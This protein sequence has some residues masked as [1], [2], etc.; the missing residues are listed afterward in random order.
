M[1]GTI[2]LCRED[3]MRLR[4]A[5]QVDRRIAERCAYSRGHRV[6]GEGAVERIERVPDGGHVPL[7]EPPSST[8]VWPSERQAPPMS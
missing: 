5:Q 1:L 3:E 4:P 6:D 8:R 2:L 7:V